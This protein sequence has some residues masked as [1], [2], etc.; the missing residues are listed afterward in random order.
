MCIYPV[1]FFVIL[2]LLA[3]KWVLSSQPELC[4]WRSLVRITINQRIM[5]SK[6][7]ELSYD[8]RFIYF[9]YS[10]HRLETLQLKAGFK[11]F[12]HFL[13]L[14]CWSDLIHIRTGLFTLSNICNICTCSLKENT[15]WRWQLNWYGMSK[16]MKVWFGHMM[17]S[18]H[19]MQHYWSFYDSIY[20]FGTI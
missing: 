6:I 5:R 2:L 11:V 18:M 13:L 4:R 8:V 16:W 3:L 15:R 10:K 17:F 7:V 9:W 20:F 14:G 1:E 12:C 19:S